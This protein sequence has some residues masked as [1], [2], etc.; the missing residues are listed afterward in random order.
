MRNLACLV[1]LLPLQSA[2][3][4][5]PVTRLEVWPQS[6]E[7]PSKRARIQIVV[8]G[9]TA[10][11]TAIDLTRQAAIESRDKSVAAVTGS[12]ATPVADGETAVRITAAG[13]QVSVPV[14][15]SHQAGED[16]IRFRSET[17]A[18]L[19]KQG[20]NAGSC[21]GSP[22]GKG[23]FSLSLFA[24]SPAIDEAALIR[25]GLGRRTNPQQPDTSLIIR[26]PMLRIPHVGGKK[27]RRSDEAYRIL[28]Q[29]ILEGAHGHAADKPECVR[30]EVYPDSQRVLDLSRESQVSQQL[31]V[32]SHFSDG[33][34]RDVTRIATYGTSHDQVAT[35]DA[36]GLV[37]AHESG[38]SAVT[39]RY[40]NH[41]E[42]VYFTAI[43]PPDG[44]QWREQPESGFVDAHVN[45]RLRQMSVLPSAVCS[46]ATFIRRVSLGLTG[47][48]PTVE[49][50]RAFLRSTSKTKRAEQIDRL[51]VSEEHARFWAQKQADLMRVNPQLLPDGR[52]DFLATWIID[53]FRRN[54]PYDQF[55]RQVI[56]ASGDTTKTA[57]ANYF[58]AIESTNDVIETT[59]QVFM[60]T[61][62]NCARCHNHPF[63]NWTQ[64]DYYRIGAVFTRVRKQGNLI[65]VADTGEMSHPASGEVMRP[66]GQ[67]DDQNPGSLKADRRVAFAAWLTSHQNPFFARVE[68]NRIWSHLF[69]RGIVN[70]VDDFRSSNPPSNVSLLDALA[71]DFIQ[72]GYDRRHIIR[73]ICNSETWQRSS[74]TD[75]TNKNDRIL[76]SHAYP[77]L[78]SAEQIFDAIGQVTATQQP[79]SAVAQVEADSVTDLNTLLTQIKDDQPRW[80]ATLQEAAGRIPVWQ[81]S[82][83]SLGPFRTK[84]YDQAVTKTFLGEPVVDLTATSGKLKWQPQPGWTDGKQHGLN[85]AVGATLL[86]RRLIA[87]EDTQVSVSLGT[88]DGV[89]VWLDRNQIHDV[90]RTRGLQP[91]Q[92]QIKLSLTKGSHELLLRIANAGAECAF[93]YELLDAD[94]KNIPVPS[95]PPEILQIAAQP[96]ASRSREDQVRLLTWK[97]ESSRLVQLLRTKL[98]TLHSRQGFAT[99]QTVPQQSDF[100]TAFGQPKRESPCACERSAEP[101]L[102]QA[103]QMLN[104]KTVLDQINRAP[105]RFESLDDTSLVQELY[106][107]ALCRA[108]R[109]G[110]I[111]TATTYLQGRD[112]RQ[113]IRDLV[114]A[115]VNTQ[116]F[117]LQH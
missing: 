78:L 41:L 15:V 85:N 30:I 5:P 51:L 88:D 3:A 39:I 74:E 46:D 54:Q 116:E 100:L 72:S 8:T 40:L 38:L 49:T 47:L 70:P 25:D 21:H 82:W 105:S 53:S 63:E 112:R 4:E 117:L 101:T 80:E 55:A 99:Q 58:F 18:V 48:L 81:T 11:G 29:W 50:T 59:S 57:P 93:Q 79:V 111:Q 2:V 22:R 92:D 106:L 109:A 107:A 35:V 10:S 31:S 37:S 13:L 33:T 23:G 108:P 69:G 44:F 113:A 56:T 6:I 71:A 32:I 9:L 7:L 115:I 84:T 90:S 61:R 87:R 89:R 36:D 43:R 67:R 62:L 65:A 95:S 26:K 104:G 12:L 17:L 24:Y 14:R 66:W 19:T 45:A 1:C 97:Q 77:K 27:L 103:L 83:F 16:P 110:E 42:S 20:C 76:F 34:V 102:D 114:W 73:T 75:A 68:V 28:H 91:G 52:A 60:G 86:F 98:K 64:K 94:G 96:A